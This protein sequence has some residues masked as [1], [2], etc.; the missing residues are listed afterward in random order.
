MSCFSRCCTKRKA[1]YPLPVKD[2]EYCEE[3]APSVFHLKTSLVEE[4]QRAGLQE[5]ATMNDLENLR[6]E[7]PG[8]IRRKGKSIKCPRDGKMGASYVHCLEGTDHVGKATHMLSYSGGYQ[9]RD[10]VDALEIFCQNQGLDM[11]RTYVWICAFCLNQHRIVERAPGFEENNERLQ[12]MMKDICNTILMISSWRCLINFERI[13]D[14]I[15]SH[16]VNGTFV[17]GTIHLVTSTRDSNLCIDDVINA[18]E[19]QN[20]KIIRNFFSPLRKV[21]SRNTIA[22]DEESKG[23]SFKSTIE[24]DTILSLIKES[25]LGVTKVAQT[26]EKI[27]FVQRERIKIFLSSFAMHFSAIEKHE[28]ALE[29]YHQALEIDTSNDNSQESIARCYVNLGEEYEA[30]FDND[31]AIEMY[32]KSLAIRQSICGETHPDTASVYQNLG[33]LYFEQSNFEKSLEM[34]RQSKTGYESYYGKD[35]LKCQVVDMMTDQVNEALQ[36]ILMESLIHQF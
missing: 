6:L 8:I 17:D 35:H 34:F 26:R 11:K 16:V 18:T 3:L 10:V 21:N 9:Y 1:I 19:E 14:V 30:L 5:T 12:K 23:G 4:M 27:N 13:P 20:E 33:S 2:A 28:E 7:T 15:D 24:S 31:K 22:S 32:L 36:I 25:I 29:L